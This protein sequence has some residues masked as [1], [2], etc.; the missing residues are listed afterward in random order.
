[1]SSA[2]GSAV[3]LREEQDVVWA[4]IDRPSARNAIDFEVLAGLEAMVRRVRETQAKVLVLRGAGGTFCS[5]ADLELLAELIDDPSATRSFMA[6]LGAVLEQ[7]EQAP[8]V[9]LAVIEGYALAGG[10]ELMLASDI[11]LAATDAKIGDRHAELGLL[12][13]AGGSVRLPRTIPPMLARYLLLTGEMIS[14][15]SAAEIGLVSIAVGPAEL[16]AEL[17]RLL[18]RLCDRER[19]TIAG[20]KQML[21]ADRA[22]LAPRLRA[23][24][25][26]FLSHLR[27]A[28]DARAGLHSFN[29]RRRAKPTDQRGVGRGA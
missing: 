16:D 21:A 6:R 4:L 29:S 13:A 14:G 10:C 7:L 26:L 2:S 20:I 25:S 22:S 1:M 8:W 3:R 24:L 15:A 11:A 28:P 12:P 18:R 19:A 27:D 9:T 5:G 23:E 17:D